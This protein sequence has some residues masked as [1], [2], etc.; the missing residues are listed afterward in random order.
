MDRSKQFLVTTYRNDLNKE[1][2]DEFMAGLGCMHYYAVF[3]PA[4]SRTAFSCPHCHIYV[5]FD[6]KV[7][8]FF[9]K[10]YFDSRCSVHIPKDKLGKI[11]VL[12][13]HIG[14]YKVIVDGE[15]IEV[16]KD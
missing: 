1:N 2:I 16:C 6:E 4:E 10:D 11:F 15:E 8:S 9:V 3:H 5:K 12:L 13:S 14:K 7:D